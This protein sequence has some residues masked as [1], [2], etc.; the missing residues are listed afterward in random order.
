MRRYVAA[1][2][3]GTLE[4]TFASPGDVLSQ[5]DLLARMDAR[6]MQWELDG[7]LAEYH[8]VSKKRDSAMANAQV[9]E[10]QLAKLEM[11]RIELRTQL[12]EHRIRHLEIRS[13]I[14]GIVVRGDLEKAEG[15]PLTVGQ[16]LFEIAPLGEMV[17]EIAV[18]EDEIQYVV[19]GSRV[20]LRLD[21]YPG[22]KW[23]A[24]VSKIHPRS[25]MW[26]ERNVFIAE[27]IIQDSRGVLR[28]GM[29]GRAKITGPRRPL[30]WNLFHRPYEKLAQMWGW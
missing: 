16:S 1:P 24:T 17:V 28:P 18:P 30:A 21:A 10:A 25:E 4:S 8:R 19:P 15:A 20:V 12:L 2:F 29:K 27:C 11:D 23:D 22:S 5:G 7:L 9:A 13:P 26:D 6:E 3:D 14:D